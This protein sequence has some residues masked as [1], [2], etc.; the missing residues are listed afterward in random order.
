MAIQ[1]IYIMNVRNIFERVP[2]KEKGVTIGY[3]L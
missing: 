3:S 2:N 1:E